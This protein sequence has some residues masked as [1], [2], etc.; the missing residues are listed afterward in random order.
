MALVFPR[1]EWNEVVRWVYRDVLRWVAAGPLPIVLSGRSVSRSDSRYIYAN[2]V[3]LAA[4]L[5]PP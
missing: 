4:A 1:G 5:V 3:V 2:V